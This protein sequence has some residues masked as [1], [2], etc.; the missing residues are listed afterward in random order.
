[1]QQETKNCPSHTYWTY[2]LSAGNEKAPP[3]QKVALKYLFD[4]SL[5]P[6][7]A[8]ETFAHLMEIYQMRKTLLSLFQKE[9]IIKQ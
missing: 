3:R 6:A 1:M 2:T 4:F 7:F 5:S 9:K 8:G